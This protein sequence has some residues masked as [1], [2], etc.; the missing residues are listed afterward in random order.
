MRTTHHAWRLSPSLLSLPFAVHGQVSCGSGACCRFCGATARHLSFSHGGEALRMLPRDRTRP[1]H[2][3]A[4]C[5]THGAFQG[6]NACN[7]AATRRRA[8]SKNVCNVFYSDS[9][10]RRPGHWHGSC[11]PVPSDPFH[12]SAAAWQA[13]APSAHALSLA[14]GSQQY[15]SSSL[16][17]PPRRISLPL[18]VHSV[19]MH[20]AFA[21]F[22]ERTGGWLPCGFPTALMYMESDPAVVTKLWLCQS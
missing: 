15:W 22:L 5:T 16:L 20:A 10:S 7:H 17:P 9:D 19:C 8:A 12:A 14:L 11:T 3:M 21:V 6:H 4:F 2:E 1:W 13:H 18:R